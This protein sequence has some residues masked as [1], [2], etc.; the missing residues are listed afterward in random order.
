[1]SEQDREWILGSR[2]SGIVTSKAV[3]EQGIHRS[4]LREMVE[5]KE[6]IQCARGIYIIADE[7]EDEL[8]LFQLKYKRGI[9]SHDT[10]LY[11]LNY[12]E[13]VPRRFH[14]TFST[15]Y[16]SETLQ[17]KNITMTR[18][19]D[20]NYGLGISTATIPSGN[21][22]RVYDLER[23]L[24][25]IM[26]GTGEDIQTVQFAMKKYASSKEKDINKLMRYAGQ[27]HVEQKIRKYMEALL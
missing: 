26:R 8:F 10:A 22:V 20:E 24:C 18:V 5:S 2:A 3:T 17:K 12:S 19:N 1:M 21:T 13:R 4:V 15:K 14:M 25:D 23:S 9:F 6:L 27:L 11:L 7:W 16:H